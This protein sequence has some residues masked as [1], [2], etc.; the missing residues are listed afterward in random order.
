MSVINSVTLK[1]SVFVIVNKNG[2]VPATGLYNVY[3]C[4]VG[5]HCVLILRCLCFIVVDFFVT[6]SFNLISGM[7]FHNSGASASFGVS[8]TL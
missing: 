2:V 6:K 5:F 3:R 4:P 7:S 8:D 1:A